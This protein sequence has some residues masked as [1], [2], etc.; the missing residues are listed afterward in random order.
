MDCAAVC[1]RYLKGEER[2]L[3][4][5]KPSLAVGG[6]KGPGNRGCRRGPNYVCRRP[7]SGPKTAAMMALLR[8]GLAGGE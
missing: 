5:I 7:E 3:A 4:F 6:T 1:G 8:W 2:G